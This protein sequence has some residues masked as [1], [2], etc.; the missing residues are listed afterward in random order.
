MNLETTNTPIV[1]TTGIYDLLKDLIRKKRLNKSNEEKLEIE[2]KN[3]RQVLNRDLPADIVTV[4][5]LVVVK[6]LETNEEIEQKFVSPQKARRKNGTTSI[7]SAIGVATLGYAT[8]AII[9]W[10]LPD[11]IKTYQILSVSKLP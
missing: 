3:S 4:N 1:L 6:D 10:D 2:L 5:T 7:L 8:N 11:G 9:K